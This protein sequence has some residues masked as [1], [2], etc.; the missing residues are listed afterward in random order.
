MCIAETLLEPLRGQMWAMHYAA[1]NSPLA[2]PRSVIGGNAVAAVTA[3]LYLESVRTAPNTLF[4]MHLSGR[5]V[6]E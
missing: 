3:L 5:M 2:Q 6:V 1:F 4:Y